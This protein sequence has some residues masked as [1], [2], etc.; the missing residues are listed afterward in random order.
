[1]A[2]S[3]H[4]ERLTYLSAQKLLSLERLARSVKRAQPPVAGS[5]LECGVALGGSG[6]V[7]AMA[8]DRPR[9]DEA[10]RFDGYDVFGMIPPPTDADPPEVH[11]RYRIIRSGE[12]EGIG[13]D[14]YYGYEEDLLGKVTAAFKAHGVAVGERVRLHRGLFEDMLHPDGAVALAHIDCDWY[15]PV[16]LC[17][18]RI[19]PC[20]TVGGY[21]AFDDYHDYGGCT[22][23]VDE[24]VAA[25]RDAKF[26]RFTP[27]AV[28][29]KT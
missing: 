2:R 21:I 24:F 10:R 14:P 7:L 11:E 6:I 20:L 22:Q 12:S 19:W 29:T 9:P 8:M 18:D 23:A 1:M 25:T 3:V 16:K 17:I 4:E 27:H 28:L 13:G 26:E 5:F 15:E